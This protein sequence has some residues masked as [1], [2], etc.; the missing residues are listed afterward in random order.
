MK[1]I[2]FLLFTLSV[3]FAYADKPEYTYM[4]GSGNKYELIGNMLHYAPVKKE[5]SSSGEYSGGE[6]AEIEIS[7]SDVKKIKS[8][9]NK[10]VKATDD[11]I[12][13][14]EMGTG[15][16]I[17]NA[18]KGE[19]IYILKM[20]SAPKKDLEEFLKSLVNNK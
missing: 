8:L 13:H 4:D 5:N 16:I 7:S 18:Q 10:A 17:H 20:D 14:R 6:P 19:K 15:M 1:N 9:I 11:Q 2:L 3:C 12:E